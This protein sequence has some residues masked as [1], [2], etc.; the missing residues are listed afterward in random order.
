VPG[1]LADLGRAAELMQNRLMTA[2]AVAEQ[3]AARFRG[4]LEAAPEAMVCVDGNGRI[5]LVNAQAERLFGY[6]RDEMVGQPVEI[7][8]PGQLRDLHPG[9]RARYLARPRPRPMGADMHPAG[10]RRA[11]TTFPAEISLS[12]SNTEGEIV[13]I[14]VVHDVTG[15][16]EIQAERERLRTR[17]ERDRLE[18]QR[19]QSQRLESLGQLASGVAHDVNNLLG[20]ISSYAAFAGEE[21]AAEAARNGAHGHWHDIRDDI[22]EVQ[23]AA[24][25]SAALIR[26]LLASAR[27]EAIQ[28]HVLDLNAVVT[29]IERL[30]A[31]TVGERIELVTDLAADLEPVLADHG[32][33]EQVLVNL[34]VNARDAMPGGGKLIIQT[35]VT[36]LGLRAAEQVGLVPGRYVTVKVSDTGSGIRP[37]LLDRVFEPFFTTKPKGEGTG[38]GL[39]TI[40]RIITK[41]GGDVRIDSEPGTG[42]VLTA[43]LPV[44]DQA[45]A[46][47]PQPA[48]PQRSDGETVLVVEDEPA[49]RAVTRRIL[50]RSG[51]LVVAVASGRE[52]L[53]VVTRRLE[54][55]DLLLTDV[56]MPQMPGRELAERISIL[57]PE[58]RVVF[59]SG[60]SRGFLSQQG[61][62]EAGVHLIEKPFSDIT[63]LARLRDILGS[64]D[65]T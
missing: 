5:T 35:A 53:Q 34:A 3:A 38:L 18:R 49:L 45:V 11:G 21:I 40:Y 51:Y 59:M 32:Q 61:I 65:E 39:A 26:Q 6:G 60:Y 28:P 46:A 23:E 63:L 16:L 44:T 37:D 12:A 9:H 25:K 8:V 48:P 58:T 20:V 33:I 50:A 19:Q 36:D 29:G 24:Q 31:R 10:R 4:L 52:A 42:T 15:R 14:A 55:V 47:E 27:Q 56:V 30:L 7:L 62:L 41:A 57:R 54:H 17:T 2:L 13:T 43:L 22:G 64:A 1:E